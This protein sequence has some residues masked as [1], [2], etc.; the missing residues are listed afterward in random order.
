MFGL[1]VQNLGFRGIGFREALEV[2]APRPRMSQRLFLKLKALEEASNS[3]RSAEEP[4]ILTLRIKIAQKP[5][6]AWS[7]SPKALVYESLES[8]RVSR[9][10]VETPIPASCRPGDVHFGRIH[11]PKIFHLQGILPLVSRV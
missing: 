7:L 3:E 8:P 9:G 5:Y 10:L 1:R 6:I 4:C 2:F 11:E